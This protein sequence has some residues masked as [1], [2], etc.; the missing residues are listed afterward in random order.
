MDDDFKWVGIMFS[1]FFIAM[2]VT[3]STQSYS[4]YLTDKAAMENGYKQQVLDDGRII[5][6]KDIDE[7]RRHSNNSQ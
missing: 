6:V 5:W 3:F 2:A 1:I 7:R 4:K